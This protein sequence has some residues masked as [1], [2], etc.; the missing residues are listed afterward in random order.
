MVCRHAVV[1]K[2]KQVMKAK[3][4][5][6]VVLRGGAKKK[7]Q[8]MAEA[9]AIAEAQA[10]ALAKAEAVQLAVT[11]DGTPGDEATGTPRGAN[12][13][14]EAPGA[15]RKSLTQRVLETIRGTAE[16]EPPSPPVGGSGGGGGGLQASRR[17]SIGMVMDTVGAMMGGG[18]AGG[19]GRAG[20]SVK[21]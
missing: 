20:V 15:R 21:M 10:E 13:A 4:A 8:A 17:S 1:E 18:R 5:G 7:A 3:M 19:K 9:K 11:E 12:V 16:E 2:Q 6:K 14:L